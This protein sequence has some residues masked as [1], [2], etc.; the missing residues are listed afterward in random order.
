MITLDAIRALSW[1][2]NSSVSEGDEPDTDRYRI[3]VEALPNRD[4]GQHYAVK[5]GYGKV[6]IAHS[7]ERAMHYVRQR[8]GLGKR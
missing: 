3:T 7:P 1:Q 8:R 2:T 4:L 5:R 6:S